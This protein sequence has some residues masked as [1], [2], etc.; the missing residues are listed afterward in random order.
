MRLDLV[1]T[2]E[3]RARRSKQRPAVVDI[4]ERCVL[5]QHKFGSDPDSHEKTDH[6][7]QRSFVV[8]A[9]SVVGYGDCL[10]CGSA[11]DSCCCDHC[12]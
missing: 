11:H 10:C 4:V 3:H 9:M 1:R 8:A 7:G 6:H 5:G 2:I 12:C